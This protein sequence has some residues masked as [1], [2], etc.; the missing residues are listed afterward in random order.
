MPAS[1]I[2]EPIDV[3]EDGRL[4]I[5]TYP[6]GPLPQQLSLER[7]E[8]GFDDRV[9]VAVSGPAHRYP[10]HVLAQDRLVVV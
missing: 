6:P 9:N 7:F 2:A 10:E 4:G 8:E 1:R 5:A 3:F